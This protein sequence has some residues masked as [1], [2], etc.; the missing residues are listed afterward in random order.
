[1]KC[2]LE[3]ELYLCNIYTSSFLNRSCRPPLV[4]QPIIQRL[5]NLAK[6]QTAVDHQ[7]ISFSCGTGRRSQKHVWPVCLSKEV[8]G[9]P[10]YRTSS[11]TCPTHAHSA[12]R[13]RA[14]NCFPPNTNSHNNFSACREPTPINPQPRR[15]RDDRGEDRS[16]P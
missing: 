16:F 4:N 8:L 9:Y 12:A 13:H 6:K 1:M 2:S 14:T 10:D 11:S 3:Q 15:G 5:Y 7:I